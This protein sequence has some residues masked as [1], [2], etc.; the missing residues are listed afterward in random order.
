[1][2]R[3]EAADNG[4]M[5][6]AIFPKNEIHHVIF[7][8]CGKSMSMSGSL[9]SAMAFFVQKPAEVE[10]EANRANIGNAQAIADKR[11]GGAAASDPFNAVQAAVLQYVPDDEEN[12]LRTRRHK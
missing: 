10:A 1:M 12:I 9:F 5:V 7:T 2:K 11:I 3:R 8:V 4:A 6:P